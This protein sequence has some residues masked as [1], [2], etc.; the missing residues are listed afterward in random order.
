MNRIFYVVVLSIF[1]FPAISLAKGAGVSKDLSIEVT[2]D[3]VMKPF[4]ESFKME[5][6]TDSDGKRAM[7]GTSL[8]ESSTLQIIGPSE[9]VER[10]VFSTKISDDRTAL[11]ASVGSKML[12]NTID[13]S[14]NGSYDWYLGGLKKLMKNP[15]A[16]SSTVRGNRFYG[17][18]FFK[19]AQLF[20]LTIRN[21]KAK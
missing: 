15:N 4:A 19:E 10:V 9:A 18:T 13:P 20:F 17:M 6:S 3:Q 7:R 5:E 11:M 12:L 16:V 8:D 14:W 1:V 2:Y 21:K